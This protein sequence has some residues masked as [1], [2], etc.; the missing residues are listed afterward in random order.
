MQSAGAL[1]IVSSCWPKIFRMSFDREF[2]RSPAVAPPRSLAVAALVVARRER[3]GSPPRAPQ[4]QEHGLA[5]FSSALTPTPPSAGC[6]GHLR[7]A[8]A[9]V[10]SGAT[11]MTRRVPCANSGSIRAFSELSKQPDQR[12]PPHVFGDRVTRHPVHCSPGMVGLPP[13]MPPLKS[14]WRHALAP[15]RACSVP[16]P[17]SSSPLPHLR[18]RHRKIRPHRQAPRSAAAAD[19]PHYAQGPAATALRASARRQ[20]THAHVH[21]Q[22]HRTVRPHVPLPV[23]VAG[24]ASFPQTFADTRLQPLQL[25]RRQLFTPAPSA[26][27]G[28]QIQSMT[29]PHASSAED[30]PRPESV[31]A[32]FVGFLKYFADLVSLARPE[33]SKSIW[34]QLL[35]P[36]RNVFRHDRISLM[37]ML[38]Q[39]PS[40]FSIVRQVNLACIPLGK[41]ARESRYLR[42]G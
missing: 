10:E 31:A 29:P 17:S 30:F 21:G 5:G 13:V 42:F 16:A 3:S 18:F 1:A 14:M 27:T 7:N 28:D 41:A 34:P 20:K 19:S 9:S 32:I 25:L 36:H 6:Q 40:R 26:A 37:R 22:S 38:G 4:A 15:V 2:I 33:I 24:F 35:F 12:T 11:E 39:R 23:A 8:R